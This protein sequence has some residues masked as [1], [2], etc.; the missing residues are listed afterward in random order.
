MGNTL[1]PKIREKAITRTS[2]I[3]IVTNVFLAAFKA[4]AGL[5]AGSISV[6]LDAVNNLTD[7]FSS[8]IT[9]LGIKLAKKKPDEKHPYGYGRIE[10]FS[11]I[12]IAVIVLSAGVAS[13]VESV[14]KI[15]SPTLPEYS[16]VTVIIIV[17]SV[18]TKLV[19]GRFV[20]GQG[21]KYASDALVASGSDASFDAIISASTLIGA[22]IT[23]FLHFSVDGILGAIISA[24]I[25][26]AGVEMMLEAVSH[27]I[28]KRPDS[29]ITGEIKA[30]VNAIPGVLGTYDLIL[31]NYGPDSAIGSLHVEVNGNMT[32][33]QLHALTQKIQ[34]A[35]LEKFHIFMTVGIYAV[36]QENA[37]VISMRSKI[38]EICK[39]HEGVVNSHGVFIGLEEKRIS[40]DVTMDFS[41]AD[42]LGMAQAIQKEVEGTFPGFAVTVN[43]DTN[44][45]D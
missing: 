8:I 40:F 22:G 5:I 25:V 45:S 14:K 17:I 44:Y 28:G 36:E 31:H 42:K 20:K 32:A 19:L 16:L 35:V 15:F 29:A 6:V 2:I 9:I 37:E 13:L 21:E 12:L 4:G 33:T 41:V 18:I 23:Y 34:R 24:F 3:G 30:T 1:D 7:A 10:Y 27:V 38:G 43:C 11:T 26:K 39:G